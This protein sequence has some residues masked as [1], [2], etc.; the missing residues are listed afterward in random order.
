MYCFTWL[1]VPDLIPEREIK[2][3]L[4]QIILAFTTLAIGLIGT[5]LLA[6]EDLA[7]QSQN[8]VGALISVPIEF[9]HYEAK[10]ADANGQLG[11]NKQ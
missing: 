3:K 2:L 4:K 5:S 10:D 7:K 9:W 11:K 8:Q 6:N 1:P